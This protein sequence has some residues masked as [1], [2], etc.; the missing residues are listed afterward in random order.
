MMQALEARGRTVELPFNPAKQQYGY[1]ISVFCDPEGGEPQWVLTSG[2]G[3]RITTNW[4]MQQ[5]DIQLIQT[6]I[7]SQCTGKEIDEVITQR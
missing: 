2:D 6:V 1:M 4:T 3:N 7:E 5:S